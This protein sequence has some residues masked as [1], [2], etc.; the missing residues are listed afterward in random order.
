MRARTKLDI[1]C[2]VGTRYDEDRDASEVV[3]IGLDSPRGIGHTSSDRAVQIKIRR[4]FEDLPMR[5]RNAR[6]ASS[7]CATNSAGAS[8]VSSRIRNIFSGNLMN[9]TDFGP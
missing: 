7:N 6:I 3:N 1:S 5:P 2:E 9:R 8:P 4:L